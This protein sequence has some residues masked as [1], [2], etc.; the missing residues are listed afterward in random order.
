VIKEITR[1]EFLKYNIANHTEVA[2]FKHDGMLGI[3]LKD[4]TDHDWGFVALKQD[5][6]GRYRGFDLGVSLR[7][8]GDARSALEKVLVN[9]VEKI[10]VWDHGVP[11]LVTKEEVETTGFKS[12]QGHPSFFVTE[13]SML[14]ALSLQSNIGTPVG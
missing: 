3:V 5:E 9:P 10:F 13:R 4:N 11:V 12:L 7:T 8:E 1:K 6:E 2:W 14:I